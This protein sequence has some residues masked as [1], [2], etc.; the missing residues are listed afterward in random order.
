MHGRHLTGNPALLAQSAT[1]ATGALLFVGG[2]VHGTGSSL[3]CPDWPLCHGQFFPS[4]TGGVEYEHSHRLFAGAVALLTS[5][6]GLQLWRFGKGD[7]FVRGAALLAPAMVLLQALLG[8]ITVIFKLPKAVTLSHLMLSM[9]FFSTLVCISVALLARRNELRQSAFA[10]RPVHLRG[11]LVG[12]S[13][14]ILLQILLGG[15]VRHSMAGLG[16]LS[17]PDCYGEWV[18]SHSIG[19][20]H[21]LHRYG[22]VLIGVLVLW[23]AGRLWVSN[24]A[25]P[26]KASRPLAAAL[27]ILVAL[28][29]TLGVLSVTTYLHAPVVALHLMVAGALLGVSVA[30]SAMLTSAVVLPIRSLASQPEA[31]AA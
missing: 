22:G 3:A 2:L 7:P 16:C 31:H 11:V 24:A 29:I 27:A 10:W 1:V 26:W 25:Y 6:L 23:V 4:M 30:G 15:Y 18:P 8:G 12:L 20:I 5:W 13:V 17:W 14:A 28:Q 9:V 19:L 21:M